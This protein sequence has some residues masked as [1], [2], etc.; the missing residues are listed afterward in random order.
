VSGSGGSEE[1][2]ILRARGNP[3][4]RADTSIVVPLSFYVLIMCG[5]LVQIPR[6]ML[7][8][9]GMPRAP[10]CHIEGQTNHPFRCCVRPILIFVCI[11]YMGQSRIHLSA[12]K[13]FSY[14]QREHSHP[15]REDG[16]VEASISRMPGSSPETM[17]FHRDYE[18]HLQQS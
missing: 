14:P 6:I 7:R 11:G 15:Q 17:V 1:V 18:H 13:L 9:D 5:D 8:E 12:G 3:D 4:A 10:N 2:R 16:T